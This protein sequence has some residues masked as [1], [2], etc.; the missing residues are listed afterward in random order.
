M[1][2]SV[3]CFNPEKFSAWPANGG[4][5]SWGN[6]ILVSYNRGGFNPEATGHRIT[7]DGHEAVFARSLDGGMSWRECDFDGSIYSR[8]LKP[9]PKGGF[10]FEHEGFV[11]RVG[12]PAVTIKTDSFIVSYDRG[13]SWD[14]PFAFPEF[15]HPLTSRTSYLIE[16]NKKMRAFMSYSLPRVADHTAYT[17]RA[18]VALTE[19]GGETWQFVGD[20]TDD[21]P[22]SVMPIAVRLDDGTLV[23]SMRRRMKG[24]NDGV[25]DT[26]IE[27]R[28]SDDDGKTWHMPVRAA[29]TYNKANPSNRNGNPPALCRLADGTLVLAYGRREPNCPTVRYCIS[30][31]GGKTFTKDSVLRSDPMT[32]DMGYPRI[33]ALPDGKCVAVYYIATEERPVQHIEA[34]VFDP[35]A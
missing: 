6:E 19:D 29:D 34:T 32:E 28:R 4:I 33:V 1:E 9:V 20:I 35:L 22:R 16:G 12:R 18:F 11:M 31:D 13:E 14:G 25:D 10:D 8:E 2:H 27:V 7:K 17:D 23:A 3:V 21:I 30:T 26:W 15:A 24:E 5:W